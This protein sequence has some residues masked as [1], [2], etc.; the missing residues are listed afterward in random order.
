MEC[1]ITGS[2]SEIAEPTN[3]LKSVF[4]AFWS[5]AHGK[6]W[7][8]RVTWALL[9]DLWHVHTMNAL[10]MSLEV[11]STSGGAFHF[12][13]SG[14]LRLPYFAPL[15]FIIT[16]AS[17][18]MTERSVISPLCWLSVPV[19]VMWLTWKVR[20]YPL[21]FRWPIWWLSSPFWQPCFISICRWFP[22]YIIFSPRSFIASLSENMNC[23]CCL[24]V[25]LSD[26]AELRVETLQYSYEKAE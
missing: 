8:K 18:G 24:F 15:P 9:S 11:L 25:L 13:I 22:A 5:C 19:L 2:D 26:R 4:L 1:D 6:D 16:A 3:S 23:C 20:D 21:V 14:F 10:H 17:R 12:S 7:E